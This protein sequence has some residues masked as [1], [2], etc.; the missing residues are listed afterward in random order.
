M[1]NIRNPIIAGGITALTLFWGAVFAQ[2]KP[3]DVGPVRGY[4]Q[5]KQLQPVAS[6]TPTSAPSGSNTPSTSQRRM[7]GSIQQSVQA[8]REQGQARAAQQREKAQQR[9]A[10]IQDKVKHKIAARLISQFDHINK[11]WTDHFAQM[12]DRYNTILQK[13]QDRA[14]VAASSGK[15]VSATTAKIQAAKAAITTAR[16]AVEAQAAKTYTPSVTP[17]TAPSTP[18]GQRQLIQNFRSSFKTLRDQLFKDLFTLRDG[19]MRDVR[20]AVQDALQTLGQIPGVD[21]GNRI[22]AESKP[23][24]ASR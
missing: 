20:K 14:N 13:I 1:R 5:G 21:Q 7:P 17:I 6:R 19:P 3:A 4:S 16:L 8:H 9:V 11:V 18:A 10:E 15:D 12:L 22:P 24:S 23:A 2:G